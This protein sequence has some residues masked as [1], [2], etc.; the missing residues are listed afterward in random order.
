MKGKWRI[1]SIALA[2]SSAISI[3]NA[4]AMSIQTGSPDWEARWDNTI[5]YNAGWRLKNR[6]SDLANNNAND[7]AE[8]LFD[9]G[10]MISNRVD[11]FS[12]L[13]I[14]YQNM[15]GGRVSVAAWYDERY[16][17]EGESHPSLTGASSYRD[18]KFSR[19]TKRYYA[20]PSGELLDAFVWGNFQVGDTD[21]GLMVGRHAVLWGE[22]VFP[23]AAG[24][25]VAFAQTPSNGLKQAMSPGAT[26]KET[27]LPLNQISLNW[28]IMNNVSL[29]GL[30]TLEWRQ[31]RVPEGGTYFGLNDGLLNGPDFLAP[32]IPW[33]ES[34]E[35]Q[36]GDWGVSVRWRPSILNE[37][38]LGFY[39]RQFADKGASWA[40]QMVALNGAPG[41]RTV[42]AEDIKL[43]GAS[44]A[45]NI[46]P[47]AVSAELSY[48]MDTPLV[49]MSPTFTS[50]SD[51]EGAR[52]NTWHFLINGT[53]LFGQT[54]FWDTALLL[55]EL[56]YQRLGTVKQNSSHYRSAATMQ[57]CRSDTVVKGCATKHAWHFAANFTPTW[58]QVFPSIDISAPIVLQTG[59]KGNA[60]TGGI[61]EGG[62]VL[63][64]GVAA[65]YQRRHKLEL[66][67]T[68]YWGKSKFLGGMSAAGPFD[69]T[70]GPLAA[71]EDR[72][73]VSLTY[74]FSF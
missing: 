50:P 1:C 18:N 28:Q 7:Q 69:Q 20:G 26:A 23:V 4:Q 38:T 53:T 36:S 42:Y 2:V 68:N 65:D 70:N 58:Q 66:A 44:I 13:D 14:T 29:S 52:G 51:Y 24:N 49:S 48:R 67:Y 37:P 46:G 47:H 43:A 31:S 64:V 41:A 73:Y 11:L 12:E 72:D 30:Y 27:S 34:D 19:Y 8:Y 6:D 63:R 33:V 62:S 59:L 3:Q 15:M 21:L 57:S 74:D 45:T 35:P 10:D 5:R 60:P 54:A 40:A 16:G 39:Y 9:K 61:N 32:G 71:R 17:D 56:T 55:G 25:S 22:S